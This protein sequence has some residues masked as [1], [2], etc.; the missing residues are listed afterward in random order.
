MNATIR[1]IKNIYM[2]YI[3]SQNINTEYIRYEWRIVCGYRLEAYISSNLQTMG[4]IGMSVDVNI[5]SNL[6]TR[7]YIG[8]SVDVNISSNLQT[9]GYIGV[10]RC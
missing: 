7:G 3:D 6:Q 2:L 4:Y 8:M 1:Q 10:S 9:R 5:S